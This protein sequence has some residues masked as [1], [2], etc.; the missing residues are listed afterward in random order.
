LLV[1]PV[2][3]LAQSKCNSFVQPKV[4]NVFRSSAQFNLY[5]PVYACIQQEASCARRKLVAYCILHTVEGVMEGRRCKGTISASE[6]ETA[7][8][9]RPLELLELLASHL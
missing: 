2:I 1:C 6:D 7:A 4:R 9:Q 3:R 8:S 5:T